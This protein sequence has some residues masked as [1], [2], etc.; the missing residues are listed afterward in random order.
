MRIEVLIPCLADG[1]PVICSPASYSPLFLHTPGKNGDSSTSVR[2][3]DIIQRGAAPAE[4]G[5]CFEKQISGWSH[6][7]HL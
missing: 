7:S 6:G 4:Y 5:P 2:H 3:A 1:D